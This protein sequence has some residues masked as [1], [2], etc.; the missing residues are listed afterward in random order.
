MDSKELHLHGISLSG[1][2][3]QFLQNPIIIIIQEIHLVANEFIIILPNF[4]AKSQHCTIHL[5]CMYKLSTSK[6]FYV[7]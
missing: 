5:D 1:K 4:V 2:P 6:K 7:A 3:L